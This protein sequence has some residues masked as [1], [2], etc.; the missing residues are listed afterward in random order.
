M[1]LQP[2]EFN[3]RHLRAFA[4]VC[5][6]GSFSQAA[7][8][9]HLT[10][11]AITN[12]IASLER[13]L[14]TPLF[15]RGARGVAGTDA[16]S[17]FLFRIKRALN[18]LNQGLPRSSTPLP[19]HIETR[20]TSAQLRALIAI[21][22]GGSYTAAA[23]AIGASQPTVYRAA[24]DLEANLG[25]ALFA[26]AQTDIALTRLGTR[27]AHNARLVFAE[28]E[29]GLQELDALSGQGALRIRIGALPLARATI[30]SRAIDATDAAGHTLRVLV[31]DGPYADLLHSLRTGALD[32]LVGALRDPA[33]ASDIAQEMLFPDRLG[34]FCGPNHP[35]RGQLNII[36]TDLAPYPWVVP[37]TGT[38]TRSF[39]DSSMFTSQGDMIEPLVE[40]SS[41]ILVRDLLQTGNR[42]T[43]ISRAQVATELR[44]GLLCELP[45]DLQDP[46]RPI[47]ITTRTGW[48]PTREQAHF[49]DALR[50]VADREPASMG[51][52]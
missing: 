19:D 35:L 36:P 20:A 28:I 45:I 34:V 50:A 3:L 13:Q 37:R 32:I 49:L 38:P 26:K 41:M 29:Q 9:M 12:A 48:Y 21:E 31:D 2:H 17:M 4:E 52:V 30:L 44:L 51:S 40:T 47:G 11:P 7:E 16:A 33:P 1:E 42:L 5:R 22:D 8:N 10:Q 43:L 23:R 15:T 14:R 18:T 46:P 24:R 6:T 39:F 27:L 25:A